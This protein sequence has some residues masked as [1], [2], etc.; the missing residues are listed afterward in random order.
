MEH[1]CYENEELIAIA[2]QKEVDSFGSLENFKAVQEK[3]GRIVQSHEE[4]QSLIPVTR[5]I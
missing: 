4:K 5:S 2:S 1:Y 3:M